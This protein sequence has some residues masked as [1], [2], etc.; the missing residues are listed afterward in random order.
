[1]KSTTFSIFYFSI[2][3]MLGMINSQCCPKKVVTGS[4]LQLVG[5]YILVPE[6]NL[7]LT[8]P[9]VC[10]SKCLYTK[11][12]GNGCTSNSDCMNHESCNVDQ[13]EC[14]DPCVVSPCQNDEF[15]LTTNHQQACPNRCADNTECDQY[16]NEL[17]TKEGY[18]YEPC[19]TNPCNDDMVC[20]VINYE[21]LCLQSCKDHSDCRN[22]EWC[23]SDGA[24]V[25]PC[26]LDYCRSDDDCR[27]NNHEPRCFSTCR[28]PDGTLSEKDMCN[29]D[30]K[31][32]ADNGFCYDPCA[33]NP[34]NIGEICAT[35]DF[36]QTC[37]KICTSHL[38]C[39]T[40]EMCSQEKLCFK[41]C[42][43]QFLE[44]TC[45]SDPACQ[46]NKHIP[47]CG[48][49]CNVSSDCMDYQ[50]CLNGECVDICNT[51]Q[52]CLYGERCTLD[53]DEKREKKCTPFQDCTTS[54]D[55]SSGDNCEQGGKCIPSGEPTLCST[56]DDCPA[57]E[58][59]NAGL[60]YYYYELSI[61]DWL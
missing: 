9:D 47:L 4:D 59:C 44:L 31:C 42:S 41:P 2:N 29:Q 58:Y 56:N 10:V 43:P 45:N 25:D 27:T 26:S 30:Q 21:Q 12:D 34:C 16:Q 57:D 22:S 18:C 54:D 13:E 52:A 6:G 11:M 39:E 40:D 49:Y 23:D 38:D 60:C 1:M 8:F 35:K 19:K 61:K 51:Y 3:I 20:K 15:C 17:C 28:F 48:K 55:C 50:Q 36:V 53:N 33:S 14:F 7:T 5:T 24:C 32:S 37:R 46:T